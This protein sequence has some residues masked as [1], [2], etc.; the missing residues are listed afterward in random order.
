MSET[1][2]LL[3]GPPNTGKTSLFNWLTGFKNKV[4]NYP[5]STVSLSKGRLLKKYS[6]SA[7]A[8]D[9][10]GIYSLLNPQSEDEEVSLKILSENKEKPIVILVLDISKLE[11]QLPLFFEL[12]NKGFSVVIVLTMS[13][14]LPKK[15]CPDSKKLA[16]LL[17]APVISVQSKTGEGVLKL[18]QTLKG[19]SF[20]KTNKQDEENRVSLLNRCKK[21]VQSSLSPEHSLMDKEN[22]FLSQKWDRFFL[23]PKI[24]LLLFSLIMFFLFSSIFWM[25]TPFMTALDSFFSFLIDKSYS[26]LSFSPLLADLAGKGVIGGFAAVLIFLPQIFILFA[27]ISFLE[28]TGYLARAAALMDGPLSKIGL[29]GKAFVPFLS[30][31][32]CA[33]PAI[34]SAKSLTSKREKLMVF[35]AIPFM[36][37]SARLPVYA[38]LLSFLFYKDSL[39]KPG[40]ALT[41]IYIGSFLVGVLAVSILNKILKKEKSEAFLLDLPVYRSPSLLK[42]INRAFKQSQH[43]IVKAG[44]AIFTVSLG[45][46]ALSHFPYL[47]GLSDS[48]QMAQSYAGQM[49]QFLEPVFQLMGLDWRVGICLILAFA[50]REVFVSALLVIFMITKDSMSLMDSLLETMKTAVNSEGALIFST[51]SSLSLIVFFMIS[52]QCLST[53]AIVY[54]ESGSLR[55]SILQFVVLNASAIM[56]AILCYQALNFIL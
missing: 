31:Y 38:L 21:I 51:A 46:W 53:S 8:I 28:D 42:I 23:D 4:V 15:S 27:G 11:I 44:P 16:E 43:Y 55:F 7:L 14:L 35:F 56:I 5:G 26:L 9:S 13:D 33:I 41:L 2:L 24:G 48:E 32:A 37:C 12:K 40:L 10:P 30:G 1:K 50:A 25:A 3:I 17:K 22:L 47:E 52:L 54:K 6:Y 34:L 20:P 49:G 39:W 29:S 19:Y 45:L 36:S 18:I